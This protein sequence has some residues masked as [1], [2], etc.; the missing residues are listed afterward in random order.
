MAANDDR[1]CACGIS[2]RTML[3]FILGGGAALAAYIFRGRYQAEERPAAE[4]ADKNEEVDIGVFAD[5]PA[6]TVR[7]FREQ[8]FIVM[9]DDD[10]IY[11]MSLLCTH[12]LKMIDYDRAK[13][14]FVCPAHGAIFAKDGT[15]MRKPAT[16]DLPWYSIREKAGRLLVSVG[17]IVPKGSK[18]KRPAENA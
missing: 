15:V 11:A 16:A 14:E 1:A 13:G 8:K 5:Y 18:I 3:A 9:A 10:G 2:R 7:E 12:K 6:G 4:K 17:Q